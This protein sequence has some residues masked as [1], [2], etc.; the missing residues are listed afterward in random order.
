MLHSFLLIRTVVVIAGEDYCVIAA[1]T[2]QSE[3]YS[4]NSRFVPKVWKLNDTTVL[5]NAGF[6]ADGYQLMKNVETRIEVRKM[7]SIYCIVIV[8]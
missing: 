6:S 7:L 8:I 4:I 2:R 3:G 1:D 5:A